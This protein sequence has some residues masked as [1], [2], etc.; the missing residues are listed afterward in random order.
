[1]K[2][3]CII[4]MLI[5]ITVSLNTSTHID[6]LETKLK[7]V[8][9]E[10]KI[11]VLNALS[12]EYL[13][14]APEQA[15]IYSEQAAELAIKFKDEINEREAYNHSA[16]SYAVIK[17]YK[18]TIRL[19]EMAL[20]TSEIIGD[21]ELILF[22]IY[23]IADVYSTSK[24]H[25]KSIEFYNKALKINEI[26]NNRSEVSLALNRIGLEYKKA[27]Q[28]KKASEFFIRALRFEEE[29]VRVLMRNE[30]KQISE[31]YTSRG[32]DEKALE[33]YKL[34]TSI[35]DTIA[36]AERSQ[37]ISD[38]Q[39][40]YEEEQRKRKIELL[41]KEKEI[42]DLELQ[43]LILEQERQEKEFIAAQR[44]QE[45]ESLNRE[46][47]YRVAQLKIA[48]YE[49][50]KIQEKIDTYQKNKEIRDLELIN[51]ASQIKTQKYTQ[52]VLISGII[53]IFI[54]AIVGFYL[55]FS[56]IKTNKKLKAAYAKLEQI[57]KTDPLTHLSNRRDMIEKMVHEQKRFGRNG[58][59]FVL[60]MADIDDFKN[61]NDDNGHD[62]G[63][64]ILESLA[65]QM[66]STVRQQDL[67]GRWGGEEFLMLLPETEIEGGVA[68]ANKIRKDIEATSYVFNEIKLELTMT[69]GVSVYDRP[70]N[71]D[72]CIKMADEALYNG[73]R[74]G[75]NCVVMTKPKEKPII[76]RVDRTAESG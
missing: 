43:H 19:L 34:F 71:I 30:Y 73:K 72:K 56:N 75:K 31:F 53:F 54:F 3:L 46:K 16:N 36:R 62:C 45:I 10:E 18:N 32:E 14:I 60:V 39:Y 41:Q 7:I 44:I 50:G 74:K 55:A 23:R 40:T 70:M 1:M 27:G 69:F 5:T 28:Y 35:R 38:M 65:K 2:F 51:R 37:K 52:T 4:L 42:R 68:L 6:S 11:K 57:A 76:N 21:V 22:D 8:V 33:Y 67:T 48:G 20:S 29:N 13:F 15:I 12:Q 64:F 9:A 59:S 58:K 49:K 25:T 17:D 26:M 63:D 24:N 47:E 61:I 66:K